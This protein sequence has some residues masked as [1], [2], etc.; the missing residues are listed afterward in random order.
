MGVL[1][2][3]EHIGGGVIGEAQCHLGEIQFSTSHVA[4]VL[5][6]LKGI[7]GILRTDTISSCSLVTF[8]GM[9]KGLLKSPLPLWSVQYECLH[10]GIL[11]LQ[12]KNHCLNVIFRTFSL[13]L[14]PLL[15]RRKDRK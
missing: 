6:T 9:L 5:R 8:P 4:S 13:E 2:L 15:I 7:Q 1:A 11:L 10:P 12:E 14:D 3:F